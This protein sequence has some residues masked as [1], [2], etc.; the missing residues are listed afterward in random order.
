MR[1]K[2]NAAASW[3]IAI[4]L[5]VILRIAYSLCAAL[6]ALYQPVNEALMHSNALTESL[7]PPL[8]RLRF[9]FVWP[10][11]RFDTL[12][13]LHIAANGY[14]R[15]D[16]VVFFPLYPELIRIFSHVMP[17]IFA[18]LSISTIAALF[19]FWGLQELLRPDYGE[20]V[21]TQAVVFCAL[22][23]ASFIFFAGYPESLLVALI[24]WSLRMA[25]LNRW[26]AATALAA[27]AA[28]TKAVGLVVILPLMT[29]AMRRKPAMAAPVSLVA[30]AFL[31]CIHYLQT[32]SGQTLSAAYR[33]F[34]R[35][36]I[37]APWSTLHVAASTLIH[38]PDP[39]LISNWLCLVL[40]SV[41]II[42]SRARIEYLLYA[43]TAVAMILCKQTV[44]PL[45]SMVRYS[46]IVF[47][48]FVGLAQL[49][50]RRPRRFRFP[51]ACL[52]LSIVNLGLLWLFEGWSLVV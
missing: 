48:V 44:P 31:G 6:A 37:A 17:P 45:Q 14:D 41:L 49:T 52:G 50:Q 39:I 29:I 51:A 38:A 43:A 36:S 24:I 5:T 2:F 22:W 3:K 13:Y 8:S 23:P 19:L 11:E 35:T 16:S 15:P 20:D 47:P 27:A 12:W 30:V 42:V 10:W 28:W 25:Q 33:D 7:Q 21:A 4:A 1:D 26:A 40:I 9:L 18:A 34:W 32:V 46:L